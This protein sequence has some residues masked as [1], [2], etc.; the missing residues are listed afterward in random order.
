MSYI[1]ISHDRHQLT[2]I[3]CMLIVNF[4]ILTGRQREKFSDW[5]IRLVSNIVFQM[6]FNVKDILSIDVFISLN[7]FKFLKFSSIN[8]LQSKQQQKKHIVK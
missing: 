6:L 3:I 1:S 8:N 2:F 4:V 5:H 7:D